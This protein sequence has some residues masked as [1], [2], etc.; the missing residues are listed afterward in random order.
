MRGRAAALIVLVAACAKADVVPAPGPGTVDDPDLAAFLDAAA[1]KVRSAPGDAGAWTELA[2]AYD[3]N[4]LN[5]LAE[6]CYRRALDV[7]PNDAKSWYGL[8]V[9]LQRQNRYDDA[10]D[11]ARHAIALE[12]DYAP[13]YRSLALWA[14]AAGRLDD[15]ET[16]AQQAVTVSEGGAGALIALGR[17]QMERGREADA[18]ATFAQAVAAWPREWGS[19][20]YAHYLLGTALARLGRDDEAARELALGRGQP[21]SLPDPWRGEVADRRAGFEAEMKRVHHLIGM[22]GAGGAEQAIPLLVGLRKKRPGNEQVL[23]D[24]GTAYLLTSRRREAIAVLEECVAAHPDS[25]DPRLLLARGLWAEGRREDAMR[26]VQ[27]AV[28]GHPASGSAFAARGMLRLRGGAAAEALADFETAQR[29][30]PSDASPPASAGAANLA[31]GRLDAA[32]ESFDRA[33]M[34]DASQT[35]AIAGLAILAVRRGDLAAADALLARIGHL[36][37]EAAPLVAE[38]RRARAA[39]GR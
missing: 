14:L 6:T 30:D 9:V 3:A 18:A 1:G 23:T 12:P 32:R 8:A 31:L 29:L 35:T 33:L 16:T 34:I 36:P 15:A 5:S 39:A 25:L 7:R 17:V 38:A 10:A 26:H 22:T 24:L 21:P 13:L 19:S 27:T 37:D 28:D 20:G 11:A 2:M 4:A